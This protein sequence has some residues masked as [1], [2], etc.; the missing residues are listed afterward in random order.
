LL[1]CIKKLILFTWHNFGHR[2]GL[3]PQLARPTAEPDARVALNQPGD[4]GGGLAGAAA[5]SSAKW[6]Q[7]ISTC[8][9]LDHR[10]KVDLHMS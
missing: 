6:F 2:L 1:F 7:P 3:S 8:S 10:S 5:I 9:S 4:E